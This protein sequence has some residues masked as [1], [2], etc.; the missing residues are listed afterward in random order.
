MGRILEFWEHG[1]NIMGRI[2]DF[3][4]VTCERSERASKWE[5]YYGKNIMGSI[6]WEEFWFLVA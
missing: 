4:G 3:G 6:L 1:K 5:E 2:M